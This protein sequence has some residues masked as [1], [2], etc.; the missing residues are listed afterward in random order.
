MEE[1][2]ALGTKIIEFGCG[3]ESIQTKIYGIFGLS[4]A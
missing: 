4:G 2:R 1:V 3:Q